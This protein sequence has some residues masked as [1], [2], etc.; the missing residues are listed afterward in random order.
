MTYDEFEHIAVRFAKCMLSKYGY[1]LNKAT[2]TD[3]NSIRCVDA[4]I[5]ILDKNK[6][7]CGWLFIE[8]YIDKTG[9]CELNRIA[10]DTMLNR[11]LNIDNAFDGVECKLYNLLEKFGHLLTYEEILIKMDLLGI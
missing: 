6:R 7:F 5:D 9:R 3:Y 10:P 2:V 1:S 4:A 11:N 8:F